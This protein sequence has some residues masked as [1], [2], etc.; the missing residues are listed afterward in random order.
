[1]NILYVL[2]IIIHQVVFLGSHDFS[3]GINTCIKLSKAWL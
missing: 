3:R 2:L 1:M